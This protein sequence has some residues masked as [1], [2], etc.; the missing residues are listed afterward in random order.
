VVPGEIG[1]HTLSVWCDPDGLL[2]EDNVENNRA[3]IDVII[4]GPEDL[5]DLVVEEIELNP[6]DELNPADTLTVSAR[7]CNR[8]GSPVSASSVLFA[9]R[10]TQ[11]SR[12]GFEL[13][14]VALPGPL[15]PEDCS[16]TVSLRAE[17]SR[18]P[19]LN[20][21]SFFVSALATAH[22]PIPDANESDNLLWTTRPTAQVCEPCTGDIFDPNDENE[23]AL[24]EDGREYELYLCPGDLDQFELP[25]SPG[26]PSSLRIEA[27]DDS[28]LNVR[29]DKL[30]GEESTGLILETIQ[31]GRL[32]FGFYSTPPADSYILSL[33]GRG[34]PYGHPFRITASTEPLDPSEHS[35]GCSDPFEYND[36]R[37]SA[38]PLEDVVDSESLQIC[39]A[40]DRDV[41]SLSLRR[42]DLLQVRAEATG[43]VRGRV[44]LSLWNTTGPDFFL[45]ADNRPDSL[46][47]TAPVDGEYVVIV[48]HNEPSGYRFT[49]FEI[50]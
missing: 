14:T 49:A 23:P 26:A 37:D 30:L 35:P 45:P 22:G 29:V 33:T 20:E 3:S 50:D 17:A 41:F 15:A 2:E 1:P 4:Y 36:S 19:C 27:A 31:D 8:G 34:V 16:E 48:D 21:R 38:V 6:V 46:T 25:W 18:L 44:R 24:L 47:Y 12:R 9:A 42:G 43:D 40:T 32:V 39:P 5:P 10:P 13:G 11:N 28:V 7:V